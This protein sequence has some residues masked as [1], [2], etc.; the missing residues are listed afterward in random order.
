MEKDHLQ[1]IKPIIQEELALLENRCQVLERASRCIIDLLKIRTNLG[2]SLGISPRLDLEEY[3]KAAKR[4]REAIYDTMLMQLDVVTKLKDLE[5]DNNKSLLEAVITAEALN[6]YAGDMTFFH[7]QAITTVYPRERKIWYLPGVFVEPTQDI[8]EC[9]PYISFF[10]NLFMRNISNMLKVSNEYDLAMVIRN[11]FL[12]GKTIYSHQTPL[13]PWQVPRNYEKIFSLIPK[14]TLVKTIKVINE[15]HGNRLD[16]NYAHFCVTK[17]S[18]NEAEI[19]HSILGKNSPKSLMD[20]LE[21]PLPRYREQ[22][23]P[24]DPLI[25][26]SEATGLIYEMIIEHEQANIREMQVRNRIEA[27]NRA[28][29]NALLSTNETTAREVNEWLNAPSWD[30]K[31]YKW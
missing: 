20:T 24:Y 7:N 10:Q 22:E 6:R 8:F 1:E 31:H 26:Y 3:D 16:P 14:G 29:F 25:T 30:R 28:I 23:I 9:S 19:W 2:V 13:P 27:R 12:V 5:G 15:N 18:Q 4:C 17:A 11:F 21:R